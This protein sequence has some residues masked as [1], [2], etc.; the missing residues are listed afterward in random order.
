MIYY[1]YLLMRWRVK[2]YFCKTIL[3]LKKIWLFVKSKLWKYNI[4]INC[5]PY[6][7]KI[8]ND[9]LLLFTEQLRIIFVN[10]WYLRI[11]WNE[12]K[13][14]KYFHHHH[15]NLGSKTYFNKKNHF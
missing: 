14:F 7:L 15:H 3:K 9:Q 10:D 11:I 13:K 4:I 2:N 12:L 6:V 8:K 5:T 1:N